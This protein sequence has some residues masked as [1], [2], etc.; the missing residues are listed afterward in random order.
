MAKQH[1]LVGKRILLVSRLPHIDRDILH[2][3]SS[4]AVVTFSDKSRRKVIR[5]FAAQ[6]P[7]LNGP[8]VIFGEDSK[9]AF[10]VFAQPGE[11]AMLRDR[12]VKDVRPMTATELSAQAWILAPWE[13]PPLVIALDDGILF[14]SKDEE[15]NGP[16][17]WVIEA[18]GEFEVM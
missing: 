13:K 16:G 6:D 10:Y 17:R 7:E 1:P 12:V 11:Q 5:I 3:D 8:G 18:Q 4:P 9:G 2:W 14:P 15:G